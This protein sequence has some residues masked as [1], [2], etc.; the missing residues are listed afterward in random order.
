MKLFIMIALISAA[1]ALSGCGALGVFPDSTEV[2]W[3]IE[4]NKELALYETGKNLNNLSEED[5][6]KYFVEVYRN[7]FI[8]RDANVK[9]KHMRNISRIKSPS[10][11]VQLAAI[12]SLGVKVVRYIKSPSAA[13]I[14]ATIKNRGSKVMKYLNSPSEALLL[15]IVKKYDFAIQY[16]KK[17]SEALQLIAVKSDPEVIVYI[18]N[19]SDAVQLAAAENS[20]SSSIITD[21]RRNGRLSE[22]VKIALVKKRSS[23]IFGLGRPASLAVQMV[24]AN[25]IKNYAEYSMFAHYLPDARKLSR[26]SKWKL[27]WDQRPRHSSSSSSSSSSSGNSYSQP[28]YSPPV[29]KCRVQSTTVGGRY[30]QGLVCN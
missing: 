10:D 7:D 29:E 11:E 12:E 19:P 9:N 8:R 2:R 27:K 4:S 23:D 21:L 15:A 28:A 30:Q 13:V 1:T 20:S 26:F 16:I 6:I 24:V 3:N 17:P 25:K 22:A 18:E 5:Q 14:L